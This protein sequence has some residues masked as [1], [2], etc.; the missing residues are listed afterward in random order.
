MQINTQPIEKPIKR[1][2]GQLE[3]HSMFYTIQGEGP[4]A[5]RP[6]VFIRLAGCNLQ[7]PGCDTEYTA[8]RTIMYPDT[9]LREAMA[10]WH[11]SNKTIH[12]HLNRPLFV[13]TGGEPF[14]Q[15]LFPL[16]LRAMGS[17]VT[18]QIETNGVLGPN[19]NMLGL[20][21]TF[22]KELFVV[23]SPKTSRVHVL[24]D[25]YAAA[26]KYVLQ[27]DSVCPNDGLP[28]LALGHKA[29]PKVARPDWLTFRGQIYVNPM[30]EHSGDTINNRNLQA[31]VKSCLEF[32]YTAGVQM[33]KLMEVE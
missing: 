23:V 18:V 20:L 15:N 21:R 19:E 14:R 26:F 24:W 13:I 22:H 4:F 5:G 32:G 12:A 6:S 2:S 16:C 17:R 9:I 1:E 7:C 31:V 8:K 25:T 29:S 10:L 33:H 28:L 27:A 11:K 3:V 30:D